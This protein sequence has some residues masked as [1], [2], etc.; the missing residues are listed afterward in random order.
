[1][2]ITT[3]PPRVISIDDSGWGHPL[4]GTLVGLHDSFDNSIHIAEVPVVHYQSP[5]FEAKTYL[6]SAANKAAS[7]ISEL[8]LP[9]RG[10]AP[11]EVLFKVCTGYVN[12]G[13]VE[14]LRSIGCRVETC[15]IGEPLQSALE[16]A[17]TDY[18]RK[19]LEHPPPYYDPKELS[20]RGIR[21]AYSE[22]MAWIA[23]YNAWGIAKTGWRSMK[24]YRKEVIQ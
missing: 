8:G 7:L 14:W 24:R 6:Q 2:T 11:S 15:R 21:K 9:A 5:G 18:V 1:M 16:K 13:I 3:P 17:H 10:L 19:N 20:N 22:T 12:L 23:K 4:L